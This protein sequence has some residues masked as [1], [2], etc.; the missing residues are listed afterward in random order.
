MKQRL[1]IAD[2]DAEL[3]DVYGQFFAECGYEVETSTNGLGCLGKLRQSMPA[4]LV[5]DLE[6]RWGGG[7]GVLDWMREVSPAH[8]IPVILTATAGFPQRVAEFLEAP[9]VVDYLTKPFALS[10]LLE[11][12]RSA[13]AKNGRSE[14]SDPHLVPV[15]SELFI[16]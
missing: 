2:G 6:I 13:I 10:T 1:L 12:V 11:K 7:D 8:G 4:A 16:G 14:P 3:C 9:P 5:L 15:Y